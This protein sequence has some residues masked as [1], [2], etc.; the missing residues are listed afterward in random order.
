MGKDIEDMREDL[1]WDIFLII[2][3]VGAIILGHFLEEDTSSLFVMGGFLVF[4]IALSVYDYRKLE[5]AK[6]KETP[7][8]LKPK[9]IIDVKSKLRNKTIIVIIFIVFI[10]LACLIKM[11]LF[12]IFLWG[13]TSIFTFILLIKDYKKLRK[14]KKEEDLGA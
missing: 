3:F 12:I 6:I 5:R 1:H 9:N 14:L 7:E 11:S 8:F 10:F 2:I 13:S 4:V